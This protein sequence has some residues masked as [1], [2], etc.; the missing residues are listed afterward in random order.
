[1]IPDLFVSVVP[2]ATQHQWTF[3][4]RHRIARRLGYGIRTKDSRGSIACRIRHKT[5]ALRCY[6]ARRTNTA[7]VHI[8]AALC[9]PTRADPPLAFK[10]LRKPEIAHSY[11]RL[12]RIIQTSVPVCIR[13][14]IFAVC[15]PAEEIA[16]YY[17]AA[18]AAPERISASIAS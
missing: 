14:A 2:R 3:R 1:M 11:S 7:F 4:R 13:T 8:G 9:E 17:F 6:L 10:R 12:M 18:V 5:F 15:I 16:I